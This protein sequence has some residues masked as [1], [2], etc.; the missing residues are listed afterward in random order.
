MDPSVVDRWVRVSDRDSF[1]TARR[2]ARE[3]GLLVGGS[4]GSTAWAALQVAKELG[5]DARVLSI[6]PDSG[7]AYLSKFYDD[8]WL[9]QYGFLER[10]APA[11]T[12]EELLRFRRE[13]EGHPPALLTV[14]THEKVGA[15][16]DLMQ[17]H[18]VSQLLVVRDGGATLADVVGSLNERDLLDAVFKNPDALHGDVVNVM[19]PP[20]S[21]VDVT[22]AIEEVFATL[23]G[24]ATAVVVSRGGAPETVL[25]RSDLLEFLARRRTALWRTAST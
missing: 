21:A 1:L 8:N 16:I 7:R 25:T 17:R 2:L 3:E 14:G 24:R 5:P 18:G 15:A 11:P 6:F 20:L 22:A 9:L 23:T 19:A 12:V 10:R 4:S 13:Q